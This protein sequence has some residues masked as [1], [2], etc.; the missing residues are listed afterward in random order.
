MTLAALAGP[1][2]HDGQRHR[3]RA[4]VGDL[5]AG[6][7]GRRGAHAQARNRRRALGAQGAADACVRRG[8]AVV[9]PAAG[10]AAAACGLCFCA[11]PMLCFCC[12]GTFFFSPPTRRYHGAV[13]GLSPS[14]GAGAGAGAGAGGAFGTSSAPSVAT[15]KCGC[16]PIA[17]LAIFRFP[18]TIRVACTKHTELRTHT[19]DNTANA[20]SSRHYQTVIPNAPPS[21]FRRSAPLRSPRLR[22]RGPRPHRRCRQRLARW[23]ATCP[24]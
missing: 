17:A 22:R 12:A 16:T 24:G 15:G 10:V 9:N 21:T 3:D 8:H 20:V 19:C 23:C 11:R 7:A 13:A 14:G 6:A 18:S 4:F 1:L 5:P 2:V